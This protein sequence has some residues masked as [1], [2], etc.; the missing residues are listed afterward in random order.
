MKGEYRMSRKTTSIKGEEVD[1]D[2]L[3]TKQN[4]E[5]KKPQALEVKQRQDFVHKKRRSR[6][7]SA[8]MEKIRQRN[9]S[10]SNTADKS[11]IEE[12]KKESTTTTKKK[13]RRTIVK[14]TNKE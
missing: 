4:L 13:K 5:N 8:A 14:N 1:F 3:E 7:R 12:N 6:G 9:D 2:L 10:V 11:S